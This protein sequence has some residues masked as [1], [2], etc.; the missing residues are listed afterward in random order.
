MQAPRWPALAPAQ[1]PGRGMAGTPA[2]PDR[3]A[4]GRQVG[5]PAAV[6][7]A[8]PRLA[9]P[10]QWGRPARRRSCRPRPARSRSYLPPQWQRQKRGGNRGSS[11]SSRGQA[12]GLLSP[13]PVGGMRR[14]WGSASPIRLRLRHRPLRP[15]PAPGT[16]DSWHPWR[17][18][19]PCG[20]RCPSAHSR[21]CL[22]TSCS[23]RPAPH[24]AT[25]PPGATGRGAS[26]RQ[27]W[28]RRPRPRRSAPTPPAGCRGRGRRWRQGEPSSSSSR[29]VRQP[30][31]RRRRGLPRCQQASCPAGAAAGPPAGAAAG[32]PAGAAAGPPAGTVAGPP[33]GTVAGPPA[34]TVAGPPAGTAAG[35]PA[36]AAAG[37]PAGTAAGPPAGAAAVRQ[38]R[39]LQVRPAARAPA[40][41]AALPRLRGPT[42]RP[43]GGCPSAPQ[44][45]GRVPGR[46]HPAAALPR[47]R[48]GRCQLWGGSSRQSRTASPPGRR[49]AG[50]AQ[51]APRAGRPCGGIRGSRQTGRWCW[52]WMGRRL[53][54]SPGV[55]CPAAALELRSRMVWNC[56]PKAAPLRPPAVRPSMW[57]GPPGR[58]ALPRARLWGRWQPQQQRLCAQRRSTTGRH[59]CQ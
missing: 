43:R 11:S 22:P 10:Q 44:R 57:G 28:C 58:S 4:R 27:G 16:A 14:R 47:L 18:C 21:R 50:R 17:R 38:R 52:R 55:V 34:G 23:W 51:Q 24:P 46:A 59:L 9:R 15:P 5:L 35:P 45:E 39:H 33:A 8:S 30:R 40:G 32:P 49:A 12:L 37:P 26:R 1:P 31:A 6:R 25:L 56:C 41:E 53:R 48:Q 3:R 19:L 2:R 20:S 29:A 42:R 54:R 7:G 36:G 13:S